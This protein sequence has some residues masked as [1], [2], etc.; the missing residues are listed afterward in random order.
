R[1]SPDN[2]R[3]TICQPAAPPDLRITTELKLP[4]IVEARPV[5]VPKHYS[6]IHPKDSRPALPNRQNVTA[7]APAFTATNALKPL[8]D[9][10]DPTKAHPEMPVP[11]P[12]APAP[13][14]AQANAPADATT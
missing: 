13:A 1:C 12:S 5:V 7:A 3:Q 11:P 9:L 8:T 4:N 14:P 6:N 2:K 10:N